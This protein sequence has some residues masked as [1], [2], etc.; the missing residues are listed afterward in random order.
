MSI[1][2]GWSHLMC[3]QPKFSAYLGDHNI[4]SVQRAAWA[5]LLCG[6]LF[7]S[8][9]SFLSFCPSAPFTPIWTLSAS[10]ASWLLA[11]EFVLLSFPP[12]L[13][14]LLSSKK[15]VNT[16]SKWFWARFLAAVTF[17]WAPWQLP[18][19]CLLQR[20]NRHCSLALR[21]SKHWLL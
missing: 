4:L 21:M 17:C 11:F 12:T 9:F 16:L 7:C 3:L 18:S 5:D 19:L 10:L 14:S 6:S 13:C 15:M 2:S 8:F 1:N 20:H